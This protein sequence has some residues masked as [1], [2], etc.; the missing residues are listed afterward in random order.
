MPTAAETAVKDLM[1][2]LSDEAAEETPAAEETEEDGVPL[3]EEAEE[4]GWP[5]QEAS[6]RTA[7]AE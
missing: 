1:T 6:A 2:P 5:P 7:K 4:T 3:F